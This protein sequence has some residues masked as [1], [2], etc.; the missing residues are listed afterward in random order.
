MKVAKGKVDKM[1][2]P[3]VFHGKIKSSGYAMDKPRLFFLL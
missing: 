3:L 2:Q 1:N